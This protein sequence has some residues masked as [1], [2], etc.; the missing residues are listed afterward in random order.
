MTLA[1]DQ[2]VDLDRVVSLRPLL[3]DVP[4]T[5]RYVR[6]AAAI[7]RRVLGAWI[8]EGKLLELEGRTLDDF[9]RVALRATYTKLAEDEDF[10]TSALVTISQSSDAIT[11]RAAITL[12]DGRTYPLEVTTGAAA[13]AIAALGAA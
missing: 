9:Q 4:S 3:V 2:V 13:A 1:L 8:D 6:G 11:I 7:L 12:V 10:V 5:E